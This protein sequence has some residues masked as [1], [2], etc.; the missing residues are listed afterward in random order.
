MSNDPIPATAIPAP[1]ADT[2]APVAKR[3]GRPP[4]STNKKKAVAAP[5]AAVKGRPGRKPKVAGSSS[6]T[7]TSAA[8][9]VLS[10]LANDSLATAVHAASPTSRAVIAQLLRAG[11]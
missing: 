7:P 9:A 6:A 1:V 5:A 10:A 2:A 4:G 8:F 11:L 3:R